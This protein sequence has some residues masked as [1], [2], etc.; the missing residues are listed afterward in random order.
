MTKVAC[1]VLTEVVFVE[2]QQRGYMDISQRLC[3]Y[4]SDRFT[5][6]ACSCCEVL[7]GTT[8]FV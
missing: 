4:K 1:K 3:L 8:A 5:S 6:L 7:C 2:V